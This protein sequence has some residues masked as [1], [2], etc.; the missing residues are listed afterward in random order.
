MTRSCEY[1]V[2][3]VVLAVATAT[4]LRQRRIPNWLTGSAMLL[5]LLL[6]GFLHGVEG[7]LESL[8]ATAVWLCGGFLFYATLARGKLGAGDIKLAAAAAGLIGMFDALEL[9]FFSFALHVLWMLLRWV[10]TGSARRNFAQ[11]GLWLMS[12]ALRRMA[13]FTFLPE[14]TAD[15]SPHAPF[16]LLAAIVAYF[17][18]R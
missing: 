4:D 13:R 15:E 5:G 12:L 14:G 7:L 18:A 10:V 8:R 11:L 3:L 9:T 6:H 17:A 16:M 2:L 1:A